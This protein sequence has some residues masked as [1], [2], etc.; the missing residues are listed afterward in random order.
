MK[1]KKNYEVRIKDFENCDMISIRRKVMKKKN[2]YCDV[3]ICEC[4]SK[5]LFRHLSD[6]A[7]RELNRIKITNTFKKGLI[8]FTEGNP[9]FGIYCIGSGRIKVSKTGSCGKESI[10]RITGPGDIL[11]ERSLFA[12][13]KFM[14]TATVIEDATVCFIDKEFVLKAIQSAPKVAIGL[15]QKLS[16]EFYAAEEKLASMAQKSVRARTA[17]LLLSLKESFGSE[18]LG[19]TYINVKLT[20]EEM[21]SMVGT[22]NE[23]MIRILSDFRDERLIEM[24]GKIIYLLNAPRLNEISEL[25]N[26]AP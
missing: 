14:K 25:K 13:G 5:S 12:G 23:T 17:N 9:V 7:F 3:K 1:F 20:R 16:H 6:E 4:V 10:Q 2:I 11:G 24:D 21:A 8:L 19:R 15:L 26:I 18:Q 22:A